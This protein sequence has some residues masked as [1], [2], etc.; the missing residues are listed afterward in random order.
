MKNKKGQDL[1]LTTIILIV[2]GIAILIFLIF[3]F[4]TGWGNLWGKI[5]GYMGGG[6]NVDTI[7]SGCQLACSSNN[8][9]DFCES[10][11]IAKL[12]EGKSV[13]GTC[14]NF[15]SDPG[16]G[17]QSCSSVNCG[18]TGMKTCAT[19][20]NRCGDGESEDTTKYVPVADV[21]AGKKCCKTG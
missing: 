17:V 19:I 21:N 5:Q 20:K 3:G 2:L 12:G 1:S 15:A 7:V 13:R 6:S 10:V 9:Y 11:R 8:K 18:D 16:I 14:Q 4:A